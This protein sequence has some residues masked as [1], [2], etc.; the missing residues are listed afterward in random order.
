M[1]DVTRKLSS[2]MP[3]DHYVCLLFQMGTNNVAT[4]SLRS[5]KKDLMALGR[6]L[7]DS[8]VHTVFFSPHS[9]GERQGKK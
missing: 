9:N 8:G 5:I 6:Q 1:R 4:E 7:K 2:I 3:L